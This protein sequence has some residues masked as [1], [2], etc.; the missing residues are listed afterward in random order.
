MSASPVDRAKKRL[1]E[2]QAARESR[3]AAEAAVARAEREAAERAEAERQAALDAEHQAIVAAQADVA[4]TE[5]EVELR[6]VQAVRDAAEGSDAYRTV[7][8]R[9]VEAAARFDQYPNGMPVAVV[10]EVLLEKVT[11]IVWPAELWHSNPGDEWLMADATV[12]GVPFRVV[13]TDGDSYGLAGSISLYAVMPDSRPHELFLL[14]DLAK[15]AQE[16]RL[17]A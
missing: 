8:G 17:I 13:R 14:A 16:Y 3:L 9:A 7:W 10:G 5:A 15:V 2:A 11:G 1:R 12:A 6:R 4:R